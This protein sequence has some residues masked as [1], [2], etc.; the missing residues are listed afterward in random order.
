[1]SSLTTIL[2]VAFIILLVTTGVYAMRRTKNLED[3]FLGGRNVGPWISAFSYGTSYFSAVIFIGFAGSLGWKFGYPAMSIG[4]GNAIFGALLAWI[5]LAKRTRRMTQNLG[6]MTMPGFFCERYA[7][8]Y[9]KP[10]AAII[11]FIFRV[12]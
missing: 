8:P 10:L 5:V 3:F 7:A 1:M 12:P 9:L 6:A 2:L 11:I 4:V